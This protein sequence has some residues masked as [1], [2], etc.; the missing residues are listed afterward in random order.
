ML[1]LEI[2]LET[3]K[4]TLGLAKKAGKTTILYPAPAKVMSE[5][6]LENVDIFLM[7][8]NYTKC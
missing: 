6:I 3:V 1:Q 2:P 8:M 7:N 5:D 4:Y